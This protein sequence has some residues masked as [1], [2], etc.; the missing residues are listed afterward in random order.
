MKIFENEIRKTASF[1]TNNTR[2]IGSD[3]ITMIW[4]YQLNHNE[5]IL[6]AR[7]DISRIDFKRACDGMDP[8]SVYSKYKEN[9]FQVLVHKVQT[10]YEDRHPGKTITSIILEKNATPI[11]KYEEDEIMP[12]NRSVYEMCKK[13]VEDE[14]KSKPKTEWLDGLPTVKKVETYND[15]VVKVT[16]IDDTFTK[17]VCSENDHFDLDVGITICAMKRI[18]GQN[19]TRD[20]NRFIEHVH[21]VMSANEAKKNAEKAAKELQKNK[22]RKAELKKAAKN[23]KAREEQIDIYKQAILRAIQEK[24]EDDLK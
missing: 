12:I 20:Y 17:A 14:R 21:K 6:K 24:E 22:Q 8:F 11:I 2:C 1:S 4:S 10:Y 15:R 23:L 3:A 13:I 19:G 16:F 9:L 7:T 18:F 5:P